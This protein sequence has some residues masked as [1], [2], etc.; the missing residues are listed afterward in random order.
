MITLGY[1]SDPCCIK[2]P[3]ANQKQFFN[4]KSLLMVNN[5]VDFPESM[6]LYS[7]LRNDVGKCRRLS[8]HHI[9]DDLFEVGANLG[10]ACINSMPSSSA[11]TSPTTAPCS[12]CVN[13]ISSCKSNSFDLDAASSS[14]WSYAFGTL[15]AIVVCCLAGTHSRGEKRATIQIWQQLPVILSLQLQLTPTKV[16]KLTNI[17]EESNDSKYSKETKETITDTT[18]TTTS[19]SSGSSSITNSTK[20]DKDSSRLK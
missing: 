17:C 1:K 18:T 8:G 14:L 20:D 16:E 2:A 9:S 7:I 4:V 3:M 10:L 11:L 12:F 6:L 13:S 15:K 5:S 19:T